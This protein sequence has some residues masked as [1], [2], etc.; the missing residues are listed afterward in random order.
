VGAEELPLDYEYV[1]VPPEV[2]YLI[3][4]TGTDSLR[5]DLIALAP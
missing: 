5:V 3:E 2:S 1:T 4:N